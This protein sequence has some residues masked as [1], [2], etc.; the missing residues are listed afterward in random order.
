M[1]DDSFK[2]AAHQKAIQEKGERVQAVSVCLVVDDMADQQSIL[3]A[4]GNSILN[5]AFIRARHAYLGVWVALQRPI[6]VSNTIRT[7]MSSLLIYKQRNR[8]D[9]EVYWG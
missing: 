6:L 7:Q 2:L 4:T 9:F 5:S 8:N 1:I 3:H